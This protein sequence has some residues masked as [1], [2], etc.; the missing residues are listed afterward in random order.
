MIAG[1]EKL[2]ISH[3]GCTV[4]DEN[5]G[6]V[7]DDDEVLLEL[8]LQKDKTFVLLD[9]ADEWT[10]AE[11]RASPQATSTDVDAATSPTHRAAASDVRPTTP[12]AKIKTDGS[13]KR[14][15][16]F[17]F[18]HVLQ[19]ANCS[20]YKR[21][22]AVARSLI[23]LNIS[24][25]QWD[26]LWTNQ[27]FL[28]FINYCEVH[29]PAAMH[30]VALLGHNNTAHKLAPKHIVAKFNTT[31][32]GSGS[33]VAVP[34]RLN[35]LSGVKELLQRIV[36]SG[37]VPV[38]FLDVLEASIISNKQLEREMTAAKAMI[39]W[40]SA[41]RT[42]Q[43]LWDMDTVIEALCNIAEFENSSAQ[44]TRSQRQLSKSRDNSNAM[45]ETKT[46]VSQKHDS[47]ASHRI[48][49]VS[50]EE[51][52]DGDD[53]VTKARLQR[54]SIKDTRASASSLDDCAAKCQNIPR[55]EACEAVAQCSTTS[56]LGGQTFHIT[57]TE[58]YK[59]G[60]ILPKPEVDE[61]QL[62][63]FVAKIL[64]YILQ[65][66]KMRGCCVL[67]P[68]RISALVRSQKVATSA[69]RRNDPFSARRTPV[70]VESKQ[71]SCPVSRLDCLTCLLSAV[72]SIVARDLLHVMSQFPMAFPL[73]MRN[74][75]DERKYS[76]TT[77]LL[78]GVVIKWES[79]NGKI[80]EHSLFN[81]PFK[82]LV[83]VRLG[84]NNIGKSAI[85][86]QLLAKEHTFSTKGEPGSHYGKPATVDGTVEFIWLTQETCKDT[87]WKPFISQHYSEDN[88]ITLMANLHGDAIEN[89]DTVSVLSHCFQCRYLAFIMPNCSENQWENFVSLIPSKNHVSIIRVDPAD[90][91]IGESGDIKTSRITEDSTLHKVR[92]CLD[93]ALKACS[94]VQRVAT[95]KQ[96]FNGTVSSADGIEM[97]LSQGI[98]NFVARNSCK[99]TKSH[100]R[101]QKSQ[102]DEQNVDQQ[103]TSQHDVVKQFVK[104]LQ[105]PPHAMQ[106]AVIHLEHELSRL[107]NAETQKVRLELSQ[108][109]DDF[110]KAMTRP[111]S[112][113]NKK[114]IESI[115]QKVAA[116]LNIID[117]MNLGL[118]HFFREVGHL[119][120]LQQQQFTSLMVPQNVA[121][122]FL[123][124]HPIELLDGDAGQIQTL[125]LNAIFKHVCQKHPKLRVF[126][127]SIIGL[128]SSGK[129]TL[130]NS[131]FAC[132]FA[133]SVGRCSRGLFMRLLFLDKEIANAWK[134]DAVLLIDSEGLGS[135]E[136][137]GDVEG[138]KKDRLLATFAMGISNLAIINVLG[139][140]MRELTE[141]LQIAVVTMTR[142]E[143][144]D[145]APDVLM[146]QHLLTEKNAEKL[147]QSEET[148]CEAIRNA[149]D[150]AEK[151]DM[152]VGV[153]NAKC[154]REIFARIENRTL[155]TQ[156]HPYKDGA[157]ANAPAS[158]AYH[159]DVVDLYQKILGCCRT[160]T[161]VIEFKNWKTLLESYW[162]CVTQ[163][164]FALRFKNVKEIH[165]FI[166]RGQRIAE[167]KQ[168]IDAAFSVH[169]RKHR[170]RSVMCIRGLNEGN[171]AQNRENFLKDLDNQIKRIPNGCTIAGTE[172]CLACKEARERQN[173]LFEYVQDRPYEIETQNTITE[174]IKTVRQSTMQKLTQ[175]FD[176]QT[177]QQGCC[178]EFENIINTHMKKHLSKGS[179]GGFSDSTRRQIISEI[180]SKLEMTARGKDQ[181][182][183][184]KE[185]IAESVL[186]EYPQYAN[187]ILERFN[188]EIRRFEDICTGK[189]SGNPAA[190]EV[191]Y[192][193][194]MLDSLIRNMLDRRQ[195]DCYEDGMV[196]ELS[197]KITMQLEVVHQQKKLR[198]QSEQ[199]LNIHVWTLQ[200]F[201][202][203]MED[204][205]NAWDKKNRPSSILNENKEQYT[206][207]I[208][209]RLE[210]GFTCAAEGQIIGQHLL[211]VTQ[212]KAL[213]AENSE[214]IRA[215]EGL[216]WT[217]NSEKVRLKYL[218][219]LADQVR[220][221]RFEAALAY[222]RNPT[223]EIEAWYKEAI[224]QYRSETFG[225]TFANTFET[226]FQSVLRKI[227]NA[228]DNDEIVSIAQS[229][230]VESLHY[231]PSC[232]I[233]RD[234]ASVTKEE[235]VT[236]MAVN[237]ERSSAFDDSMLSN[238]SADKGVMARLGCTHRCFWCGAM[239]WGQRGHE[240]DQGETKKHHSS[241]QPQGLVRT[242][243]RNSHHLVARPCHETTDDTMVYFGDYHDS[244]M[245]WLEAKEK[246]FSDWKF[247][248]HY[249][250]KFDELMRWF[251]YELHSSIAKDSTPLKP[252]TREE[253]ERYSCTNLK[254]NDIMKRIEQEIN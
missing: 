199:K 46:E 26:F 27:T 175:S 14:V 67:Q 210:H 32:G 49:A 89:T 78:R 137:M 155:L 113:T 132:R 34:K 64:P 15:D 45:H 104:I 40:S 54:P 163:E 56:L 121:D 23:S 106:R 205:Q 4:V 164:D 42:F 136:K 87:L 220:R 47:S 99:S 61:T 242:S 188:K 145:I 168:A 245:P 172:K 30:V 191:E 209:S 232:D 143:K 160:S 81:D 103:M 224:D 53:N 183:P 177:M 82:L 161:T 3:D 244:G 247:D 176:A 25:D 180:F 173:S 186:Y 97:A 5:D 127:V 108:H 38:Q 197:R 70:K 16:F 124:G 88:I 139:E 200:Q 68:S 206:Q 198:L 212:Q 83:A 101:L 235:I 148:F 74:I 29:P 125:W 118:E 214:K 236:T 190:N 184:V 204:M 226:E 96:C 77:P 114:E 71:Y 252:A 153:R 167:V 250:S 254:Y 230:N 92:S 120:K 109:K 169:A 110:K 142:L 100:L 7:I 213:D 159:E 152:Q 128:Q 28:D 182:V 225:E 9:S 238:T 12:S 1:C 62:A 76:L 228:S 211:K 237:K 75:T 149:I 208:N 185:K 157:T 193:K 187:D 91:D 181:D 90:Y 18:M 223:T 130:L 141:I 240:A 158:E 123:N 241:H 151:K 24:E 107:C 221:G 162:E 219:H 35:S 119:Y 170:A 13:I 55:S 251:F 48:S 117:G 84:D 192:L 95:N 19:S 150:L 243:Y 22:T 138:E 20:D 216:V 79:G 85:L 229:A 63:G 129:S 98:I 165:D 231:Q 111:N 201:C 202:K 194:S 94:I 65:R 17:E 80:V 178:A 115:R 144:A 227:E 112:N 140:Y 2:G 36:D 93:D 196:G 73:I 179:A 218:K 171:S 189:K 146:I 31:H 234:D 43:S 207:T 222:F 131:L 154:L 8:N 253:L 72:D 203:R 134:V 51:E 58:Y 41:R 122:L 57:Q 60:Q 39:H 44:K 133:V 248:R 135:P 126:V 156:F 50:L 10:P 21:L 166:D 59:I 217:T 6:T 33:D 102:A 233:S 11:P 147:S 246:H 86:N 215:V 105:S 174:F 239:C 195:A 116:T 66:A 52:S 69:P 249:N 37:D